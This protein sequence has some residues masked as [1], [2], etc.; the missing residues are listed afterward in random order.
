MT[1]EYVIYKCSDDRDALTVKEILKAKPTF[2]M[3]R[4][5]PQLTSLKPYSQGQG[6][7]F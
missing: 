2:S 1:Q 4:S 5:I 3:P 7:I 6:H